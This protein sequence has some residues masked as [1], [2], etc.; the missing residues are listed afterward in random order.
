MA[1]W[2]SWQTRIV[3]IVPKN[4]IIESNMGGI[5]C[6][7]STITEKSQNPTASSIVKLNCRVLTIKQKEN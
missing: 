5:I 2:W 6:S 1:E 4:K 3:D 7:F